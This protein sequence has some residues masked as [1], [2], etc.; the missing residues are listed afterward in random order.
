MEVL[1]KL[2]DEQLVGLYVEGNNS[3]FDILLNRYRSNVYGYIC[4][5][6]RNRQIAEDLFQDVFMRIICILRSGKSYH[7]YGRFSGWVMCVAHN[8]I[9][10]YFRKS[11]K[12]P[13]ISNDDT[14]NGEVFNDAELACQENMEKELVDLQTMQEVKEL[15][16]QLPA[17]QREVLLMRY[18]QDLS[19]KDIASITG[20]SI[21]TALGRMRYA[22]INMR[23]LASERQIELR[24]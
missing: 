7:E 12:M 14:E 1:S 4:Y 19:F 6:V 24:A 22:L 16:A 17:N 23:R 8:I 2:T 5:V 21:N 20:T 9:I 10:D 15:I 13:M 3:A 18:Y 11:G